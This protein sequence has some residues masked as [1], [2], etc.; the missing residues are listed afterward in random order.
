MRCDAIRCAVQIHPKDTEMFIWWVSSRLAF[1]CYHQFPGDNAVLRACVRAQVSYIS[2]ARWSSFPFS[3]IFDFLFKRILWNAVVAPLT[4]IFATIRRIQT[5]VHLVGVFSATYRFPLLL[6]IWWLCGIRDAMRC[7]SYLHFLL[8]SADSR[9]SSLCGSL[10]RL[11]VFRYH[12]VSG[13]ITVY[14]M[15]SDAWC[16]AMLSFTVFTVV[17]RLKLKFHTFYGSRTLETEIS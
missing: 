14:A 12:R 17:A 2:S 13:N 11:T 9:A 1:F 16:D 7:F 10:W 5:H 3:F 15:R 4:I 6:V 8:P